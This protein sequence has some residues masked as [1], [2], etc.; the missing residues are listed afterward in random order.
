[1]QEPSFEYER[2]YWQAGIELVAGIDE[3]GM[4]ALAGPVTAAAVIFRNWKLET[5]NSVAIR[6]SKKLSA[7]QREKAA[8]WIKEHALNWGVGEATVEEI[9]ALN[10]RGASHLA[11]KRAIEALGMMPE[12]LLIDGN[13]AQPHPSIPAINIVGGDAVV[14]SIAAA[15]ILAKVCRDEV[16]IRFDVQFPQYGFAGHK[17]YGSVKHLSALKQYGACPIH[18][19]TYAPVAAALFS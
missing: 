2:Q 9:T 3:A 14:F 4:G 11:M 12:L 1:M 10:I 16:M 8:E 18:R 5:G 13:P 7:K 15:S 6:D 19:P 17:G